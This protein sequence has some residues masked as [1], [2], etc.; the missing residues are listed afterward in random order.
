M[1]GEMNKEETVQ[2]PVTMSTVGRFRG[3][4]RSLF[5]GRGVGSRG[6]LN[7][8]GGLSS[9][10]SVRPGS[11]LKIIRG[12]KGRGRGQNVIAIKRRL[13]TGSLQLQPQ[14]T[15][16]RG[17]GRRGRGRGRGR[18]S[19][20]VGSTPVAGSSQATPL[21]VSVSQEQ[22]VITQ[23]TINFVCL[24]VVVVLLVYSLN[25]WVLIYYLTLVL[26]IMYV[27]LNIPFVYIFLY[28]ICFE[29][30]TVWCL[31][32]FV[33]E[34]T[35][36]YILSPTYNRAPMVPIPPTCQPGVPTLLCVWV[37]VCGCVHVDK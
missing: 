25:Q 18:G 6:E 29:G 3:R 31:G 32:F 27:I 21:R 11:R 4:G 15:P 1:V 28:I 9:S 22:M 33:L 35:G 10:P 8:V 7:T 37:W 2:N 20:S 23:Y 19:L 24:V 17:R 16:T 12:L 30:Y 5:R 34:G 13:S 26:L 14:T 36:I